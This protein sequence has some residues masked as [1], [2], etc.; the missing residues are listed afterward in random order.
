MLYD[1]VIQNIA[2]HGS[3]SFQIVTRQNLISI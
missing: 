3:M 2:L 1:T